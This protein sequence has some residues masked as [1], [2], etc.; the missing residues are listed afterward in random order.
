MFGFENKP[1]MDMIIPIVL[2]VSGFLFG[3]ALVLIL[4]RKETSRLEENLNNMTDVFR[5]LSQDALIKNQENFLQLASNQFLQL[6]NKSE[7]TLDEKRKLIDSSLIEMKNRLE[8]L[9]SQTSQLKGQIEESQKGITHLSDTTNHLRR[10]LS[11]NQTRGSWGE[12]MVE[13]I[14]NFM[15]F[16]EGL[17]YDKQKTTNTGRPDFTFK[18]PREKLVH[19]DVK[20]PMTH[21]EEYLSLENE[22]E[23]ENSKKKFIVDVKKHITDIDKRGYVDPSS[24]TL[25]YVLMFIPNES[26]YYFIHRADPG[27][28]DYALSKKVVLCSPVTLYA[29]LSLIHQAVMN[30]SM[31]EK[32]G[33]MQK[34]MSVFKDNW[35]KFVEK[36][37]K[38]GS[39]LNTV[40]NHYNEL[41]T[42]R[43]RQL[44]KPMEQI[45]QIQM[46]QNNSSLKVK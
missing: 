34:M 33:E 32:A 45:T 31:E 42:T 27:L 36:M 6:Q 13:D 16:I 12:K 2:F 44:E 15:G 17:N 46:D 21:Y 35:Q 25:D 10:I 19:M 41:T 39:S 38:L 20:F 8:N 18:L 22:I 11:S 37:D 28:M 24:G 1:F 9:T 3:A 30:F 26:I 7:A 43:A 4:K 5:N 23:K 14:L 40:Q 29:V